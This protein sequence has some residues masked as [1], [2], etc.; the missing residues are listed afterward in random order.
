LARGQAMA[1]LDGDIAFSIVVRAVR[2]IARAARAS[3]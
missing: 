1:A 3:R 2:V